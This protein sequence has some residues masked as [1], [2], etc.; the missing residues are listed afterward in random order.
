VALSG[1]IS[2]I[3]AISAIV[4]SLGHSPWQDEMLAALRRELATE[5]AE[6]V[7][8]HQ[9][10]VPAP[11]LDRPRERLLRL[12]QPAGFAAAANLGLVHADLRSTAIALV[13]DD[14]I[15]EPG[16]LAALAGELGRRPRAAA[17]QGVHL[18][19][20]RPEQVE[21]CGIGW[22]RAWQAVQVGAGEP[23]PEASAAPFEL[24]GV[25]ATAALYRRESLAGVLFDERL[26]SYYED[27]ELAVRLRE[28]EWESWCVPAA[29][30]RHAGQATA[31][32]APFGR[33]RSIHRNRL[34]VLRRLLGSEFASAL[35]RLAARDLRDLLRA[36][37][38]FDGARALGVVAGW[39]G[40]LPRLAAFAPP[41]VLASRRALAAAARFR[42]GS[43]A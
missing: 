29:C 11:T 2:A 21:G 43:A 34:L 20:D 26:G 3:S 40:A 16:W 33:W 19:L 7:W 31:G 17:V 28:A 38:R 14:L 27:V 1:P 24:F 30:A 4:P 8:V 23:P 37:L 35:P 32:R 41:S 15:V 10:A 18:E 39:A 36:G 25:S 5:D 9:G 6:L 42:I 12:P 22:N 13:N